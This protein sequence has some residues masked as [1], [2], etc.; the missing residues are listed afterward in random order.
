MEDM[1]MKYLD[2]Y[3]DVFEDQFPTMCFQTASDD[4]MIQLIKDCIHNQK[5]AEE[6]YQLDYEKNIY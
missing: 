4:E 2:E 3:A 5:T 6:L 1:L